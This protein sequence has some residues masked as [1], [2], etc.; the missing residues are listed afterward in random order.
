MRVQPT[1]LRPL[2]P[3]DVEEITAENF[4]RRRQEAAA[5]EAEEAWHRR[6]QQEQKAARRRKTNRA[7]SAA[8]YVAS[9]AIGALVLVCN[10]TGFYGYAVA[11]GIA[12]AMVFVSGL[13][14]ADLG[15]EGGEMGY[16]QG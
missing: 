6:K 5:K 16:G 2:R 13:V 3:R 15:K 9:G 1:V 10:I 12:C 8:A 7:L 4:D 11:G 14:F